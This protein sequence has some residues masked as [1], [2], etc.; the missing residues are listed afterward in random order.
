[1][2]YGKYSFFCRFESEAILPYYKGST[3][4][5]VFGHAL[6]KVVCA[7]NNENC[8]QCDLKENCIYAL[9]FETRLIVKPPENSIVTSPPPPFV[10]EPPLSTEL[11]FPRGSGFDFNLIL[12][13]RINRNYP[14]FIYALEQMGKIGIGKKINDKRGRFKLK[15]VMSGNLELYSDSDS[16]LNEFDGFESLNL[17]DSEK[18]PKNDFHLKLDIDTPLR[19]KSRQKLSTDLPFHV[20]LKAM[21]RRASF[22]LSCYGQGNPARDYR[23][24]AE[25]A[26]QVQIVDNSLKWFDWRRYSQRQESGMNLGG[27]VGSVTYKGKIGEFMPFVN[28]CSKAHMGK[29]TT[30][31]LG[32]IRT[33]LSYE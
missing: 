26:E 22:L 20:L 33:E 8:S 11:Y 28:F 31:G 24:L 23:E 27:L 15:Q 21:M 5:G 29:Q 19:F 4:R 25:K 12:F 1:M 7:L 6:K 32:K 16:I 13:G 9:A 14:Y 3:F 2:I 18:Y 10:I 17:D 30:F